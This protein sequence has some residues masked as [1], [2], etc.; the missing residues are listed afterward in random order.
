MR[1]AAS[2]LGRLVAGLSPRRI[3]FD[4]TS[5]DVGFVVN[6]AELAQVFP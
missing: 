6:R 2:L 4:R 5:V 1:K 3:E